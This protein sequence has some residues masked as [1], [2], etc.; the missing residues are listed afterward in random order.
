VRY[1]ESQGPL[2][3]AHRG[4]SGLAQENSLAAFSL[5]SALGLRYL[6]T[7]VR[8]TSDDQLVC[9]HDSTLER[10]T[11][12]AGPVRS[13]SLRELRGLRI[14]GAEP[15][16][17]FDE[18][19][20]AF[21]R[22]CFTVDPK[23]EAGLPSLLRSLR[24]RGVADRVCIA[25]AWDGLLA[26]VRAEVPEVATALGWRSL[27]TLLVCARAGI[28]PPKAVA[29][30]PFAHVPV[31]LGRVPIFVERLVEMS[32]ELG[33]QV[34]TWTVDDPVVMRRLLDAGVDAIIT[35]RP[36]I[37]REVLVSRGQWTPMAPR[38]EAV[39]DR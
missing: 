21:P 13:R 12:V 14:N 27:T 36:D 2:A 18:A 30:A 25:G 5:A 9:F 37:L 7:D 39:T 24:R 15:I 34:V 17:T 26:Q 38:H 3:I 20:D 19:L 6:E 1:G 29:T 22:Q 23:D 32:H 33:V 35:D 31:R 28:R 11:S 10:V 4:G 16:P 8:V